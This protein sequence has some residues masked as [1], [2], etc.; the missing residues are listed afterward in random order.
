MHTSRPARA[1][2]S[3]GICLTLVMGA[4][5]AAPALPEVFT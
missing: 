3:A 4:S 1:I 5:A 2:W